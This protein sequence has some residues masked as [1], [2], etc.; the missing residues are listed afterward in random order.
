M[1]AEKEFTKIADTVITKLEGG[2]YH[3]NMLKDGRV[4][5]QRYSSSGETMFCIDRLN[6]GSINTSASGKKFWSLIDGADAKNKWKWL[7]LGGGLNAQLKELASQMM[8]PVYIK[9]SANYLSEKARQIVDSDPRLVFHFAYASWNGA[10]WFKRFAEPINVAVANGKTNKDELVRIAIDSR[11]SSANSLIRQ[12]GTKIESF[13][14][15]LAK[16]IDN[17]KGKI[18]IGIILIGLFATA[19]VF[20]DQLSLMVSKSIA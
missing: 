3:P 20:R 2:Y 11:K 14:D 18:I 5:D 1:I 17:N 13:I 12:S 10:G 4:K 15:E 16:G 6:G 7:Y 8:Y 19:I 9:N